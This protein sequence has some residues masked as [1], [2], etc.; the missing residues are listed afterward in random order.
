MKRLYALLAL[1]LCALGAWAQKSG[2]QDFAARFMSE[3][4]DTDGVKC[5]TVG[6]RMLGALLSRD[7]GGSEF[8]EFM[9]GVR[10]IRIITSSPD[11]GQQA[12]GLREKAVSLLEGSN[13]RYTPYK[14]DSAADF[15][16]C[17][18]QRRLRK[19]AVELV[20][21]APASEKGFMVLDITGRIGS[22]FV[23]K[24]LTP[25]DGTGD[26]ARGAKDKD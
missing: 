19:V 5:V 3:L 10:S 14:G 12:E 4:G 1:A 22:D 26:T 15:G 13:R 25:E 2:T 16:D 18:W 20:Y 11:D 21:V 23:E 9:E 24:L 7:T 17:L 6:P 8:K